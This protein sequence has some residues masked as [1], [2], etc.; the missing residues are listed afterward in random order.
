MPKLTPAD[1]KAF[2]KYLA[3]NGIMVHKGRIK[4]Q[5]SAKV[6]RLLLAFSKIA[7]AEP[8]GK[9]KLGQKFDDLECTIGDSFVT[10]KDVMFD[11]Y[12]IRTTGYQVQTIVVDNKKKIIGIG[13]DIKEAIS[14]IKE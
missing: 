9:P 12:Y 14:D 5:D 8:F 10:L 3:D 2:P 1:E 6:Q 11:V 13:K 4:I 7:E